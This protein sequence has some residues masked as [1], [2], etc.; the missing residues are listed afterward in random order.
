MP[1]T[2]LQTVERA[3]GV[4]LS[5]SETRTEWGV[6]ELAEAFGLSTSTA[7]RLLAALAEQGFLRVVPYSHRYR[8]GPALWRMA[9]LWER[10]GG[11]AALA[12]PVLTELA[13]TTRRTAVFAI[14][15]GGHVR[16]VAAVDGSSGPPRS[17]LFRGALYP[18]H[19]GAASRA[20]FAFLD[21][22]ERRALLDDRPFGRF[23]DQT[24]ADLAALETE[25]DNTARLGYALSE[26]EYDT[27]TRALGL[28]VRMGTRPVAS[29]SMIE[30]VA[31][32]P[33]DALLDHLVALEAAAGQLS[34]ALMTRVTRAA[35]PSA[36]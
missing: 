12:D 11:L 33:D 10:T 27:R 29:V 21:R 6:T 17:H 34:A 28:P 3:L 4:L 31:S 22:V 16:V 23:S 24:P 36:G 32:Q 26:G 20:Y 13:A 19:A 25:F 30:D 35:A 14:P 15:D 8:L 1:T 7:Q 9:M 5:Y 18:A 2:S